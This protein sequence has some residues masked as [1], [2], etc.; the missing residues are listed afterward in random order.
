MS[1]VYPGSYSVCCPSCGHSIGQYFYYG[2]GYDT[3]KPLSD[4]TLEHITD[5]CQCQK[6]FRII[7]RPIGD[8]ELYAQPGEQESINEARKEEPTN[9]H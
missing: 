2:F 3:A 7:I 5:C 8:C 4:G 1:N 9:E 6:T